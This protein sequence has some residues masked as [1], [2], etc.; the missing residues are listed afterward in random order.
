[1]SS[2]QQPFLSSLIHTGPF[3]QTY[4]IHN[5]RQII[6]PRIRRC[7]ELRARLRGCTRREAKLC[8]SSGNSLLPTST[9]FWLL[10]AFVRLLSGNAEGFDSFEARRWRVSESTAAVC[11]A[12]SVR[13]LSPLSV[14]VLPRSLSCHELHMCDV[15]YTCVA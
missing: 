1:M 7:S 2:S 4:T 13:Q 8:A 10:L 6:T 12:H 15:N 14:C 3:I 5:N 11:S 9:K